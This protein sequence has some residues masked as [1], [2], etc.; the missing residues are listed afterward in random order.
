MYRP[1]GAQLVALCL[2]EG[3]QGGDGGSEA[4]SRALYNREIQPEIVPCGSD[5][6]VE[7]YYLKKPNNF[8]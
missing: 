1:H 2:L 5:V 6:V 8:L 3:L 7:R 4:V